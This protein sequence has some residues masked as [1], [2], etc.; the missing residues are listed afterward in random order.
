MNNFNYSKI[1]KNERNGYINI[2]PIENNYSINNKQICIEFNKNK[3][4][5]ECKCENLSLFIHYKI[6]GDENYYSESLIHATNNHIICVPY[7]YDKTNFMI[8]LSISIKDYDNYL[9][10]E[11]SFYKFFS[12]ILINKNNINMTIKLKKKKKPTNNEYNILNNY[13]KLLDSSNDVE[14]SEQSSESSDEEECEYHNPIEGSNYF[15]QNISF[16]LKKKC[17]EES[18]QE[19]EYSL[20][21][22]NKF[23]NDINISEEIICKVKIIQNFYKK[24]V[25]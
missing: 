11:F 16:P 3:I 15:L 12:P 8:L 10:K 13:S 20:C 7:Y 9:K 1:P 14:T 6:W 5:E 22:K 18:A 2:Y 4:L 25:K 24:Y 19:K 17:C 21:L 23:I